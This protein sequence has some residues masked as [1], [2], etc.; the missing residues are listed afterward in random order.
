M[1]PLACGDCGFESP[2]GSIEVS[3]VSGVLSGTDRGYGPITSPEES[4]GLCC[5]L[6]CEPETSRSRRT[7]RALG[8]CA[9]EAKILYIQT[10]HVSLNFRM[11]YPPVSSR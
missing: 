2:P 7:W 11:L 5:V 1:R 10:M 6:V 8:C 9:T 4:Y 3:L